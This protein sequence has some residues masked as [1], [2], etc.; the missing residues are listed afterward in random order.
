MSGKEQSQVRKK[1]G[2][3]KKVRTVAKELY[4]PNFA[5]S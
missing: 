5:D 3:Q 4:E 2:K 1:V